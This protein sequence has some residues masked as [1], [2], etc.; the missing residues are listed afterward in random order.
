MFKTVRRSWSIAV[1]SW[2]VLARYPRLMVLP[3]ISLTAIFLAAAAAFVAVVVLNGGF[4]QAGQFVRHID[5]FWQAHSLAFG[6]GLVFVGWVLTLIGLYANAALIFC[7][8]RCFAGREPTVRDGLTA[9]FARLPQI[10]GWAFVAIVMGLVSSFIQDTLREK[11]GFLGNLLG[12]LIGLAWAVATYFVLPVL[13][14]E[15]LGPV[16]RDQAV[17]GAVASDLGRDR[18]GERRPR[19]ARLRR[20]RTCHDHHRHRRRDGGPYGERHVCGGVLRHRNRLYR[21]GL[22]G[23]GHARD[24]FPRR[25]LCLRDDRQGAVRQRPDAVRLRPQ[26]SK[27]SARAIHRPAAPLRTAPRL[28][29]PSPRG[30]LHAVGRGL[31]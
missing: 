13:V 14:V 10:A 24:D 4:E 27:V 12:G 29:V 22:G 17:V 3:L 11:L 31:G 21:G 26:G 6:A 8:L 19:C 1:A 30:V 18:G 20:R 5:R 7:V 2:D 9:A 23:H 28:R 15:G 25:P 16:G